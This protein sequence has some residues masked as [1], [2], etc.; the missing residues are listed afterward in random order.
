MSPPLN[1]PT[2]LRHIKQGHPS[3]RYWRLPN[4]ALSNQ[5]SEIRHHLKFHNYPHTLPS[6]AFPSL[7]QN[8]ARSLPGYEKCKTAELRLFALQRRLTTIVDIP[9]AN[10]QDLAKALRLADQ[11]PQF[12]RFLE[13]PP[14]LRTAI[15]TF[16]CAG[17][18][19]EPLTLPT[20]PPLARVNRQLREEVLPVFYS[21]CTF[22]VGL[23]TGIHSDLQLASAAGAVGGIPHVLRMQ[24]ETTL[25]LK[26]LSAEHLGHIQRFEITF[27][28]RHPGMGAETFKLRVGVPR[29]GREGM[30]KVVVQKAWQDCYDCGMVHPWCEREVGAEQLRVLEGRVKGFVEGI[31]KR[32]EGENHLLIADV[33]RLRSML[34]AFCEEQ[35]VAQG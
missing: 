26:S 23:T 19:D 24:R 6:S 1:P 14:E 33:Y 17:F 3:D 21:E 32:G 28:S 16:Y 20:Y 10:R 5:V 2:Q 7:L 13:L 11:T 18:A 8:L 12:H 15:Y 9:N 31:Q 29:R 22:A 25:F 34:E 4:Y 35:C 27:D 30:A